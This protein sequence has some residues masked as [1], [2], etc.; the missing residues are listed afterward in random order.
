MT[1]RDFIHAKCLMLS[2]RVGTGDWHS[3][4]S[5]ELEERSAYLRCCTRWSICYWDF[6][7]FGMSLNVIGNSRISAIQQNSIVGYRASTTDHVKALDEGTRGTWN[8]IPRAHWIVL[9]YIHYQIENSRCPSAIA[10]LNFVRCDVK[11]GFMTLVTLAH[12]YSKEFKISMAILLLVC[13]SPAH[14]WTWYSPSYCRV[15]LQCLALARLLHRQRLSKTV[16]ARCDY[17]LSSRLS[18]CEHYFDLAPSKSIS[19]CTNHASHPSNS[20]ASRYMWSLIV[21]CRSIIRHLAWLCFSKTSMSS[22][23]RVP[24]PRTLL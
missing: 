14:R 9:I 18:I 24:P 2:L 6:S 12:I 22:S 10:F 3:C 8:D 20:R 15:F 16:A 21:S 5:C 23:H 1:R 17:N 4:P 7:N 13:L 11:I 19:T